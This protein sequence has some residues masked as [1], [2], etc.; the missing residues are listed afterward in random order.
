MSLTSFSHLGSSCSVTCFSGSAILGDTVFSL[1]ELRGLYFWVFGGGG[2]IVKS[3]KT[4]SNHQWIES[5]EASDSYITSWKTGNDHG[6]VH[7]A[8]YNEGEPLP[9]VLIFSIGRTRV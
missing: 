5:I 8:D 9:A 7:T 3:S 4:F 6:R 2:V 1:I